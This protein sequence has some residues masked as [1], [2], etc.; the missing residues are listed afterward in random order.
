MYIHTYMNDTDED[1]SRKLNHY[2]WHGIEKSQTHIVHVVPNG[3][4]IRF[5][6]ETYAFDVILRQVKLNSRQYE[7]RT[8]K[9]SP[10][11][12]SRF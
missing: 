6:F 12:S 3:H 10:L 1:T 8:S 4:R 5:C 9:N 11:K 2:R 7:S